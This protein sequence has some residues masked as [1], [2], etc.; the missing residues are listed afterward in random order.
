MDHLLFGLFMGHLP[1]MVVPGVASDKPHDTLRTSSFGD[2]GA[3]GLLIMRRKQLGLWS[4]TM[5]Q[6]CIQA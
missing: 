1:F 3:P 2:H 4:L 6:A 5:P